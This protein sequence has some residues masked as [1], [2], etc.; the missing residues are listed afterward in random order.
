MLVAWSRG[1]RRSEKEYEDE[2][3]SAVFGPMLYMAPMQ[4]IRLFHS[5]AESCGAMIGC[6]DEFYDC[7]MEF[8]PNLAMEG[9][10]EPDLL[11]TLK[12]NERSSVVLV[13]EAKW[14]SPQSERQL[15]SQWEAAKKNFNDIDVWHIFLTKRSCG[16]QEMLGGKYSDEEHKRRLKN[17]TW[18]RLAGAV[19]ILNELDGFREW[20]KQVAI[21]LS[22][23][24]HGPFV[25]ISEVFVRN[26][27]QSA[28]AT[29]HAMVW[30]FHPHLLRVKELVLKFQASVS[31]WKDLAWTF[32]DAK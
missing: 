28:I 6:Q 9:R 16:Y 15:I 7:H 17:L 24:G 2:I 13:F 14:E 10:L 23:L 8:W 29:D 31:S 20:Q 22:K 18:S 12:R 5:I 11:V 27:Y 26:K 4:R 32:G 21:F 30:V 1:K 19:T 3:L 25:G